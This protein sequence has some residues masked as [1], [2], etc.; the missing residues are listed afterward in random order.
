[1]YAKYIEGC[2]RGDRSL[3]AGKRFARAALGHELAIGQ[4]FRIDGLNGD[5]DWKAMAAAFQ[6]AGV[7][8]SNSDAADPR[9]RFACDPVSEYLAVLDWMDHLVGDAPRG[10]GGVVASSR[11]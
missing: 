6:S 4:W 3:E 9:Y 10:I 7:L 2:V 1:M 11:R 8:E 5:I